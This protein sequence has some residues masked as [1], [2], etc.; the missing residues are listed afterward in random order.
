MDSFKPRAQLSMYLFDSLVT[1]NA[2]NR[3]FSSR[4]RNFV[5]TH[6]RYPMKNRNVF[7]SMETTLNR[8]NHQPYDNRD[9]STESELFNQFTC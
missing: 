9:A 1:F 7:R 2:V 8:F 5:E 4:L 3:R 6:S